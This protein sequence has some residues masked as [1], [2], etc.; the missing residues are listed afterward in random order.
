MHV[1]R[2]TQAAQKRYYHSTLNTGPSI[3]ISENLINNTLYIGIADGHAYCAGIAVPVLKNDRLGESFPTVRSTCAAQ[4]CT[5]VYAHP[6]HSKR[7][8]HNTLNTGPSITISENLI[9]PEQVAFFILKKGPK[10]GC[11]WH[12]GVASSS[13]ASRRA[14]P[15]RTK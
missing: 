13:R 9:F 5:Q 11:L 3:T 7:Y 1:S 10:H 2:H 12:E 14:A 8:Y 6:G 4:V 15:E